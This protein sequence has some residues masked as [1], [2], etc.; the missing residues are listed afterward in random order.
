MR[1]LI[2]FTLYLAAFVS[3]IAVADVVDDALA[4]PQ[5]TATDQAMDSKRKS[6]E[7]LRF[8]NLQPGMKVIDI[9]GGGGYYAELFSYVVGETGQVTL[10]NNNPWDN[11]VAKATDTRMAGNRLPNVKLWVAAPQ[12][13]NNVEETYDAA[14]LFLGMHD[15]YY[16]D[17]KNKWPAIDREQFLKGIYHLLD[18][19]GLFGVIDHNAATGADPETIGLKLHRVDPAVVIRDIEAAGFKLEAQSDV[20]R[21]PE[22]D[23]QTLVFDPT[24][25]WQTDRSVMLFRKP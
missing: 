2:G 15:I 25:R 24:M 16:A 4:N 17:P 8:Y 22:D 9:F 11:F 14:F 18:K 10:Y 5:R 20:L 12:E 3:P 7:V 1:T 13:L 6:A 21:N 19:G 23:L